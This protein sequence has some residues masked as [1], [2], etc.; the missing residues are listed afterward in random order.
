MSL[1]GRSGSAALSSCFFLLIVSL[2]FPRLWTCIGF[3]FLVRTSTDLF[4]LL[5][6]MY[7]VLTFV[8]LCRL[9]RI[10]RRP[11]SV[12]CRHLGPTPC[13]SS[14]PTN[15]LWHWKHGM[16]EFPNISPH[17]SCHIEYSPVSCILDGSAGTNG[18]W[19]DLSKFVQVRIHH[20]LFS[21]HLFAQ[22]VQMRIK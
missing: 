11:P 6:S 4:D 21:T 13:L 12:L 14:Y 3:L 9:C 17:P 2:C 19:W 18:F 20:V 1:L 16:I 15:R 22:A 10:I 7:L 5:D 8:C